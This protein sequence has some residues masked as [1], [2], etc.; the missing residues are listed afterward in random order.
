MTLIADL[1]LISLEYSIAPELA[2]G[3]A[4]GL[5]NKRSSTIVKLTTDDGITGYGEASG[6]IAPIREYL[7]I[8]KGFFIGK[9][10]YDFELIAT[11]IRDRLDH[12]GE[13]HNISCLSGINVAA[14]DAMGKKLGVPV[15]DLLGGRSAENIPCY[16]TTGYI[17][18]DGMAGLER[19]LA[20]VDKSQFRGVKIKIGINPK[21]D[22]ERVRLAR[23]MLGDD[24]LL[25]VDVNGNYTP[26]VALLSARA[27]EPYDIHWIEE[28]LRTSDIAGH[29]ELRAR[30]PIPIATGEGYH[31]VHEFKT[32][33]EA[34]GVDI[35]QPALGKCG[36]LSTLRA[37]AL[38]AE[39]ANLRIV[40]AVWGGAFVVA[41][42]M[43]FMASLASSPHTEN[44]PYPRMLEFDIGDNPLRD[45][46]L[47][48]PLTPK[49]G[50][51]A[52]PSGPGLGIEVDFDAIKPYV[53]RA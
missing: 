29:A 46:L 30:S 49:N 1:D 34:R 12:F 32:L 19:Q 37:V 8:L 50:S 4:R 13:G 26:D 15:H 16:A 40:P 25:M 5:N 28:P 51:V 23:K 2:Y 17:T 14:F 31:G 3:T 21:S 41:A 39:T 38:L 44:P 9:R 7:A 10:L 33:V 20:A 36:G 11:Y 43:H 24:L 48:K 53:A 27:I 45:R 35:L 18:R 47:K 6:P 22:V 42:A 52:L